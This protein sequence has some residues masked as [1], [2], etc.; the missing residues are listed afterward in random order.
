METGILRLAEEQYQGAV[1]NWFDH[2]NDG[3]VD[4]MMTLNANPDYH[5]WW[6]KTRIPRLPSTWLIEAYRNIGNANHWLQVR[7]VGSEGNHEAIGAQV[8]IKTKKGRQAQAVGASNEGAFF[9]Q[10]HY[11]LYFG[12]GDETDIERIDV[13][14]PDGKMQYLKDIEGDQLLT[15]QYPSN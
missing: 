15:I 7:L 2:D 1:T 12:L 11:R 3:Q 13:R 10:G 9:S 8:I 14:W 5:P 4:V 6:R